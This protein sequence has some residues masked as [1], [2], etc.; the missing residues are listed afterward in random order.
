M[1]SG[2]ALQDARRKTHSIVP[3]AQGSVTGLKAHGPMLK[4]QISMEYLLLSLVV[5]GIIGIS[6]AALQR[7][8]ANTGESYARIQFQ[9][10]SERVAR[11]AE[12][13]CLLGPGNTREIGLSGPLDISQEAGGIILIRGSWQENAP[14]SCEMEE[15]TL[16]G[17]VILENVEGR[18]GQKK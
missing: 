2:C 11:V 1:R 17:N 4:A 7:I 8:Q 16:A 15:E 12:E 5:L 10:D 13:L 9:K 18:I 6:L 3:M 14:I